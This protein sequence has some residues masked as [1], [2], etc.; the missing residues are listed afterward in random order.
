MLC[1][2]TGRTKGYRFINESFEASFWEPVLFFFSRFESQGRL[3]DL[4]RARMG[5]S[6]FVPDVMSGAPERNDG[7]F[8]SRV[9]GGE[10]GEE[11]SCDGRKQ[12]AK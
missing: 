10:K 8:P 12:D 9:Q 2:E 11:I 7:D 6:R 4:P 3:I 1:L 5:C